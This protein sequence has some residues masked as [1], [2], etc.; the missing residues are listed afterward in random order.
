MFQKEGSCQKMKKVISILVILCL[1]GCV[2][3]PPSSE[4]SKL[5]IYD[6][7]QDRTL[8]MRFPS[9][10]DDQIE[11]IMFRMIRYSE[12]L[13]QEGDDDEAAYDRLVEAFES[14]VAYFTGLNGVLVTDRTPDIMN[15][16][17]E[18]G[19]PISV[20]LSDDF[21]T[22]SL[23]SGLNVSYS[24]TVIADLREGT[25][26]QSIEKI[27]RFVG[28]DSS[29]LSDTYLSFEK[30]KSSEGFLFLDVIQRGTRAVFSD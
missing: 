24:L 22:S 16:K 3:A 15:L 7:E 8:K 13:R 12:D 11:T 26:S 28:L 1:C 2:I 29:V 20:H 21:K 4:S 10:S 27:L 23:Q 19:Y 9:G 5:I 30:M 25:D 14:D 6:L 18:A 17:S